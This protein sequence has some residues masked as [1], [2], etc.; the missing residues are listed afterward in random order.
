MDYT[1]FTKP[2]LQFR[3]LLL[4]WISALL[5][6]PFHD[7]YNDL[8]LL[9][10]YNTRHFTSNT[11]SLIPLLLVIFYLSLKHDQNDSKEIEDRS[12]KP[13]RKLIIIVLFI[14]YIKILKV[15]CEAK[16]S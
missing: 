8:A 7:F 13:R 3:I 12:E 4:S 14:L 11:E 2:T 10:E 16:S 5:I 1:E 6:P 15:D 9:L